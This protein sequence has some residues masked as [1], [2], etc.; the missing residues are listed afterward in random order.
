MWALSWTIH[1]SFVL[2]FWSFFK[3]TKCTTCTDIK[4]LFRDLVLHETCKDAAPG[5]AGAYASCWGIKTKIY[6][7]I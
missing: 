2:N 5:W 7:H 1:A 4:T 6:A 3:K